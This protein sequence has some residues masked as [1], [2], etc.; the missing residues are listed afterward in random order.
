MLHLY[1]VLA[2][3]TGCRR[4]ELMGLQWADIDADDAALRALVPQ[5]LKTYREAV[6]SALKG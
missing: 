4:G 2:A 1:L 6:A 3:N 5:P